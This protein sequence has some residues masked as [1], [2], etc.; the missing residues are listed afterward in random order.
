VTTSRPA[1]TAVLG[2]TAQLLRLVPGTVAFRRDLRD[3]ARLAEAD[4][5]LVSFPKSGRTFVRAM[6]ARL[7]QRRFGVD[8]RKLLEFPLLRRAPSGAPRLLFTHAGDAMRR[9]DEIRIDRFRYARAKLVLLARHPADVA[10]S[11]YYHLKHRSRDPARHQLAEQPLEDFIWTD[12]GGIPSVA[13]FLNT[14]AAIPGVTIIH[15]GDFIERPEETLR[16][17]AMAIGLEVGDDDIADAADFARLPNLRKREREGYF[18]SP[19]LRRVPG[20]DANS[21]KVRNGKVGGYRE[22]LTDGTVAQIDA[23]VRDNLDPRLGF[24]SGVSPHFHRAPAA[25]SHSGRAPRNAAPSRDVA[26]VWR[27]AVAL[28][29]SAS[30]PRVPWYVKLAAAAVVTYPL[31]PVDVPHNVP[32]LGRL[33]DV[34][35]VPLGLFLATRLIPSSVMAD[36]RSGANNA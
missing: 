30:E 20:D 29:R 35:F 25:A 24:G 18:L 27:E 34:I 7:Y 8:E 5:V 14:F 3:A 36:L 26:R 32:I 22:E 31:W 33:D 28:W 16:K 23:F 6:L 19:R 13:T 21:G 4:A 9:P 12:Q 10:V 2:A 17:L 15:Y 11:R 1:R